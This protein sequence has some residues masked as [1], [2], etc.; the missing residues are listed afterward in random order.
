[1]NDTLSPLENYL[2]NIIFSFL[3][4]LKEKKKK[5]REN[6]FTIKEDHRRE[7]EILEICVYD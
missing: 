3:L 1:M 7:K 4:Q 5:K 6:Q 2:Q